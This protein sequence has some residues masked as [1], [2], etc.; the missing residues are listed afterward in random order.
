[1]SQFQPND[2]SRFARRIAGRVAVGYLVFG[3]AWIIFS[4][5]LALRMVSGDLQRLAQIQT[6]KGILFV[7]LSALLVFGLLFAAVR[8]EQTWLRKLAASERRFRGVFES[9]L[10]GL[11]LA[12]REGHLFGV[13]RRFSEVLGYDEQRLSLRTLRWMDITPPEYFEIDSIHREEVI[14]NGACR[15][16]EKE[17]LSADGRRVPVLVGAAIVDEADNDA[18]AVGFLIDITAQKEAEKRIRDLNEE[19]RRASRV[20]DEFLAMMSHELRTPITAIRL[21]LEVLCRGVERQDRACMKEAAEMI[22]VSAIQQSELI[23]D[24]LD[25][26]RIMVNKLVLN[27]EEMSL[28]EVVNSAVSAHRLSAEEAGVQLTFTHQPTGFPANVDARRMQQA[29]SN[30]VSNAVKF[31]PRG[32]RVDISLERDDSV[33]WLV[34]RDT[35]MGID[36]S[37]LPNLFERFQQADTSTTRR[38]GGMGIGLW[39][40]RHI[41][42]QHGGTIAGYSAGVGKGATFTITLPLLPENVGSSPVSVSSLDADKSL[43]GIRV[44]VVEDDTPGREGLRRILSDFGAETV[45]AD[46]VASALPL[47]AGQEF[48]VLLSD[49]AM[50]D[51][52]GISLVHRLRRERASGKRPL[53]AIALTAHALPEDRERALA[54]GFD[55]YLVKPVEPEL[56]VREIHRLL[57]AGPGLSSEAPPG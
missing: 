50:P 30:L 14:R 33:A 40:A 22:R 3:L 56:L 1:M 28:V 11:F 32:G 15:P 26:S 39:L 42:E 31:T 54:G 43:R 20:K 9:D 34:V 4:D 10:I 12:D 45:S 44:L 53:P 35:G 19:L 49:L 24:L 7:V 16:Y 51:E 2:G 36:P 47:L 21:W 18:T 29:V 25:V 27:L 6:F 5:R 46:S 37:L 52:D 48:D 23:E 8:R 13:N 55:R 41:V 57:A 38:H 17:L